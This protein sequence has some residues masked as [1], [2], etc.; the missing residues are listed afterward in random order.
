MSD[1]ALAGLQA[2]ALT[3]RCHNVYF[4][5]KQLKSLHDILRKDT[6]A[7]KDAIKQDT[8]V[9]DADATIEI[10]LGLAVIKEQHTALDPQKALKEEYQIAHGEDASDGREPW[11][12]VYVEPQQSHTPFYSVVVALSAALAAG[13]CVALKLENNLRALPSLLRILLPKALEPDTFTIVSSDP[14]PASLSQCLQVLQETENKDP[15][16]SQLVSPKRKVIAI[17]DRTADLA[18]AAECLVTARFAFGGTSPYAPDVVLVNEFVKKDLTEH[19]LKHAIRF[20]ASSGAA[21]NRAP[22]SPASSTTSKSTPVADTLKCLTDSKEWKLSVIT[23]GDAGA[24]VELA[25]TS[26]LLPKLAQPIFCL[27]AITSLEHAI[28]LIEEESDRLLTGYYFGTPSSGKYLSQFINADA[29]FVNH[30]PF[31]LLLGPAAPTF[32]LIDVDHR[33]TMQH[34]TRPSPSLIAHPLSQAGMS[35]IL[36]NKDARK[37]TAELLDTAKQ[38]IKEKKRSERIAIGYFEQGIFIGL[39]FYGI[40]ILTC[41]G[42]GLFFGVRAGLRRWA[43]V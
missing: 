15:T 33:Y 36:A 11:G 29:S 21:S 34:F 22:K 39:G 18:A 24:I 10:A 2:T 38:E 7:V 37:A 19:V 40:P 23:R 3:A 17:V 20:L 13:N 4:R 30:I 8:H 41:V 32:H 9:S 27:A 5:Q 28:S 16:Y 1:A 6:A 26:T 35:K 12:V 25:N 31:R 43:F 42:A 14:S